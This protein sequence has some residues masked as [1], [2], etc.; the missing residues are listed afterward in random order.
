MGGEGWVSGGR[1]VGESGDNVLLHALAC[2]H[3]LRQAHPPLVRL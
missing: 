1:W 2:V 3:E